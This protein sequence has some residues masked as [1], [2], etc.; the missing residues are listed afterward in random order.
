MDDGTTYEVGLGIGSW[1]M[2]WIGRR[3]IRSKQYSST[4]VYHRSVPFSAPSLK[5]TNRHIVPINP[6]QTLTTA[7]KLTA[8]SPLLNNPHS[9]IRTRT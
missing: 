1:G 2:D 3:N 7:S 9:N 8:I 6:Y 5:L 4:S